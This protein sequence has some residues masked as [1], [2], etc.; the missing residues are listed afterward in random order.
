M[1]ELIERAWRGQADADELE[2][3]LRW[4]AASP[5]NDLAYRR[6]GRLLEAARLLSPGWTRSAAPTAAEL[7]G[8]R[9]AS[10][11]NRA[12]NDDIHI[13]ETDD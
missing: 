9:V 3:L 12:P 1:D 2:Q 11:E 7:L 4:R 13:P 10:R 6:A 5:A 8:R